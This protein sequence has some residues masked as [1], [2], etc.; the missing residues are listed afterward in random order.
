MNSTSLLSKMMRMM[1]SKKIDVTCFEI[2]RN[3]RL[4]IEKGTTGCSAVGYY[5][6]DDPN[7]A[8]SVERKLRTACMNAYTENFGGA[9]LDQMEWSITYLTIQVLVELRVR[10]AV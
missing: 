3:R 6:P 8:L 7:S 5:I 1:T 9:S 4:T 10:E 2:G